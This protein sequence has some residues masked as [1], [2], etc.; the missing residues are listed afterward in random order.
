MG[1]AGLSVAAAVD[2]S[3][4]RAAYVSG[5]TS[6]RVHSDGKPWE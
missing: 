2:R 5:P 4:V 6:S 3:A 1:G